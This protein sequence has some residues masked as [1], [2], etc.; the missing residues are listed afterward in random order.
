MNAPTQVVFRD[1][2]VL[3][4]ELVQR[5]AAF[6]AAVALL[7][8][9]RNYLGEV[10]QPVALVTDDLDE[11]RKSRVSVTFYLNQ[12]TYLGTCW[13]GNET[14]GGSLIWLN[15]V[16][17]RLNMPRPRTGLVET[18]IHELAHAYTT[19]KHGWTFRRMYT[20]LQPHICELFSVYRKLDDVRETI[21]KYQQKHASRRLV[22]HD[23][24][25]SYE[26]VDRY[27]RADDEFAKHVVASN[28][29]TKRLQRLEL[30]P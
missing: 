12:E 5:A 25:Y 2:T 19:G 3:E 15:A 9:N 26:R 10:H 7:N 11:V 21:Y 18:L 30:A 8:R 24:Y 29:M 17:L 14:I 23:D 1:I 4:P 28:R 6:A 20:L 27:D 13:S 22:V 16:N